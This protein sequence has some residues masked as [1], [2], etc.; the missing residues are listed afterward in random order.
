MY[1]SS[2][3]PSRPCGRC[4]CPRLSSTAMGVMWTGHSFPASTIT[5]CSGR[6]VGGFRFVIPCLRRYRFARSIPFHFGCIF[7][8]HPRCLFPDS[9]RACVLVT[10]CGSFPQATFLSARAS[11]SP[12][13]CTSR[14]RPG[15]FERSRW[16]S[17]SLSSAH[18]A[19][20]AVLKL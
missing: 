13:L 9:Q 15:P 8:A 2:C 19:Y 7:L 1:P 16:S 14:S 12:S 3:M 6:L 17:S 20:A 18:S 4:A 5:R 10:F 11:H